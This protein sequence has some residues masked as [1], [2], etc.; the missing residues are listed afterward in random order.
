M[1]SIHDL[2]YLCHAGVRKGTVMPCT[3][4]ESSSLTL[5][6]MWSETAFSNALQINTGLTSCL[7]KRITL[8][9]NFTFEVASS[10]ATKGRGKHAPQLPHSDGQS[11]SQSVLRVPGCDVAS[12]TFHQIS[13]H[14][15]CQRSQP[16]VHQACQRPSRPTRA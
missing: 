8:D 13:F 11:V 9:S 16:L 14:H 6:K 12:C 10:Q 1:A 4:L 3:F 5:P 2:S 7:G 15:S